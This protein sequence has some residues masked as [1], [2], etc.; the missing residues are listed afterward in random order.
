MLS[1]Q[2]RLT[3]AFLVLVGLVTGATGALLYYRVHEQFRV[4]FDQSVDM[5]EGAVRQRLQRDA[6]AL[7]GRLLGLAADPRIAELLQDLQHGQS[8]ETILQAVAPLADDLRRNAD[9]DVLWIVDHDRVRRPLAAPHRLGSLEMNA[10]L[11]RF[12]DRRM[13]GHV[14]VRETVNRSG[15]Q[16]SLPVL[17][18]GIEHGR[19]RLIGGRVLGQAVAEDLRVLGV[20]H[21]EITI[22]DSENRIVATTRPAGAGS[23]E[24]AGFETGEVFQRN[25]G[26]GTPALVV[27]V[28]VS[29]EPLERR[30][31]AL[32]TTMAFAGGGAALLALLLGWFI[33]R[34]VTRPVRSLLAATQQV[35]AGNRNV[36]LPTGRRDELGALMESF[37]AMLHDLDQSEAALRRSERVAAWQEIAREIAHE[38]KNPLTP[39]QLAIETVR[40]THARKHPRFEE[41]FEESTKTIL[42]EVERLKTIVS[43]FSQ[44]ARMPRPAPRRCSLNELVHQSVVLFGQE[45]GV[46]VEEELQADLG[47][48]WLDPDRM[49]QVI[50][51]LLSNAIDATQSVDRAGRVRVAT[52]RAPGGEIELIVEDNGAGIT[53]EDSS[54]LF[55]PYFTRKAGGTGL[56]LAVVHRIVSGHDGHIE[57]DSTPGQ[58]TLFRLRLPGI[59]PRG[60][61]E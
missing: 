11:E 35:A 57:V 52:A 2:A 38:I 41:V 17:E 43:N 40:R 60:E 51:N 10:S 44:F 37:A 50:Q 33:A 28:H 5:A 53:P 47:L 49:T 24:E 42:E 16:L 61:E 56:G 23:P 18:V 14:V 13:S 26:E 48:Q 3:L 36:E 45:A 30:I 12:L 1:L 58:G 25:P 4:D 54:R 20:R 31:L 55:T 34:R 7:R 22:R 8:G 59:A 15:R 39:I 29:R 9:L 19:L 27:E 6:E 46:T 32:T 21:M